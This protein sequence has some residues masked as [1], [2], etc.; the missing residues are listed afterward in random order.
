WSN[1]LPPQE[2][3]VNLLAGNY[4]VTI[5]DPNNGCFVIKT[6]QVNEPDSIVANFIIIDE[7]CSPGNDGEIRTVMS[8]GVSPYTFNWSTSDI[9]QNISNL[10][11]GTYTLTITDNNGCVKVGSARVESSAPFTVSTSTVDVSCNGGSDG[12]IDL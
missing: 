8:G 10:T 9:T 5:T 6:Y 1:N 3:Q 11:A 4:R 2:D 7:S 12:S